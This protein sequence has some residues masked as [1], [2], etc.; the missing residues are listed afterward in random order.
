MAVLETTGRVSGLPRRTPVGG[1]LEGATFWLVSEFGRGAQ[2]VRNLEADP[3]VRLQ[4]R[5]RWRTGRAVVV[6][7]D[8]PLERLRTLPAVNSFFVRLVG[9]DL[10][11]IRVD[12]DG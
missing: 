7:D 4:V 10:L 1:R 9:P 8:V 3:R 12:L 11:T 6:D 5:G 2:Y